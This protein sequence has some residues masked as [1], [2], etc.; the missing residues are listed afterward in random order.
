MTSAL[1]FKQA[2]D[3]QPALANHGAG[4]ISGEALI[5]RW[6]NTNRDTRG[7]AECAIA[8][9]GE[10]YTVSISGVGE[11]GTIDWPQTRATILANLEEEGGQRA[12]ALAVDFDF[13]FMRV[14]SHI[15]VNKGVL[16]IVLFFIFRDD[17]GR[18][19]YLTREFFSRAD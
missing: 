15:R 19:N 6:V 7:I 1:A 10:G 16:V 9:D 18:S 13:S 12:V 11:T 14:E 2:T 8:A 3:L 5:G 4:N 17:S